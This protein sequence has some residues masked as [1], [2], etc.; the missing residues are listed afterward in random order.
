MLK[1]IL[2]KHT[3]LFIGGIA[4]TIITKKLA[5]SAKTRALCVNALAQGMSVCDHA[6]VSLNNIREEAEDIYVDAK[7]KQSE[8]LFSEECCCEIA[9]IEEAK[10]E[11]DK[12]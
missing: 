7:K 8:T 4:S 12:K 5:K 10:I 2:N 9:K 3:L 11:E 6:K 1:F